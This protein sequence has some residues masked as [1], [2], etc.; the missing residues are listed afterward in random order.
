MDVCYVY[1]FILRL[2]CP[3]NRKRPCDELINR[4]RGHTV[5]KMIMNLEKSEVRAQGGCRA[6]EEFELNE[7]D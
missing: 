4:P 6:S 1:V 3:V 7:V 5:C 2:C